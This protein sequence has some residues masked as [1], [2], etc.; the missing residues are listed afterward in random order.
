MD[1]ITK[2]SIKN[3]SK[4]LFFTSPSLNKV[5]AEVIERT[6]AFFIQKDALYIDY[7][8]YFDELEINQ[9]QDYKHLSKKG[10]TIFSKELAKS[11]IGIFN[12]D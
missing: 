3:D 9:W 11:C 10:A 2:V 7:T 5:D 8:D 6:T 1:E 4:H 12:L